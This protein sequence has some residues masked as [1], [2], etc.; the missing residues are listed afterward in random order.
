MPGSGTWPPFMKILGSIAIRV[1]LR[2]DEHE[3]IEDAVA[4]V[5]ARRQAHARLGELP[6]AHHHVPPGALVAL[7]VG[8]HAAVSRRGRDVGGARRRGT[9]VG[10][11]R[12]EPDRR[13]TGRAKSH[14]RRCCARTV[15]TFATPAVVGRHLHEVEG[16]AVASPQ[17]D[18]PPPRGRSA[19]RSSARARRS[20]PGR[21]RARRS[22]IVRALA[23]HPVTTSAPNRRRP[24][25][26]RTARLPRGPRR[27][28]GRGRRRRRSRSER[29]TA[30][31]G[32]SR[33]FAA[34]HRAPAPTRDVRARSSNRT[35]HARPPHGLVV[36]GRPL[37]RRHQSPVYATTPRS[38][39]RRARP[40]TSAVAG[41]ATSSIWR[42]RSRS[43]LQFRTKSPGAISVS[44]RTSSNGLPSAQWNT[45]VAKPASSSRQSCT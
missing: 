38:T 25:R 21:P 2:T 23:E 40:T 9:A 20:P 43:C 45:G 28:D 10:R 3:G 11:R 36:D 37:G 19:G 39:D 15:V 34:A 32:R 31:P 8:R 35:A 16:I 41:S 1:G 14:V 17:D 7:R 29:R 18:S 42:S 13:A 44:R 33:A 22:T 5:G 26:R 27:R 6:V 4:R 24:P 30:A 12:P